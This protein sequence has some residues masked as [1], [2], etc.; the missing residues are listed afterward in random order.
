MNIVY[1]IRDITDCGGIQQTTCLT[2]NALMERYPD[3]NITV[4][5]LINKYKTPFFPIHKGVKHKVLFQD[6]VDTKRQCW[7]IRKKLNSVL[8]GIKADI[9]IVQGT[10]FSVYL[11]DYSWKNF[12]VIVCEH[13]HYYMGRRFGLHWFGKRCALKRARAIIALTE[14]DANNYARRKKRDLIIQKIYNPCVLPPNETQA[15]QPASK[16]IVSCGSLDEVKRFDHA[17]EASKAVF[18]KHPDWN[19]VIYGDGKERDHLQK[20]IDDYGLQNHV[21]LMGYEKD[22]KI[23]YEDKAFLVLTSKFEGFGMVLI[24]AMQYHLPLISYDIHY[25]PQEIICNNVN[26]YLIQDGNVANLAEKID[27]LICTPEKRSQLSLNCSSILQRF[28]MD[29]VVEQWLCLFHSL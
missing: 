9:L 10:A 29:C 23:I 11:T 27:Y 22:K 14:S 26:G 6:A 2:I 24:E 16:T 13:G 4:I 17:I 28:S 15:Y 19:W 3:C 18:Q 12:K 7:H 20:M 25:G 5:S 8:Q 1:F 21:K